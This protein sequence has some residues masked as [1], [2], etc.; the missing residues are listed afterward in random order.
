MTIRVEI[1]IYYVIFIIKELKVTNS[2][3]IIV[4]KVLLS[5]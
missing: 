2:T 5:N 1:L 3:V 4:V